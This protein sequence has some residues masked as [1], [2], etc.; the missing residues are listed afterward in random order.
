MK[1][2]AVIAQLVER[3]ISNQDVASSNLASSTINAPV[4]KLV[5]ARD[6]K[7]RSY[8]VPVRVRPGVPK[9]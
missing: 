8:G 6:L 4:V 1:N 3:L 7:F 9:E 2:N 5:A